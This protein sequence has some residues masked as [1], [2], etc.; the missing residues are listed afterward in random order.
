MDFKD[1]RIQKAFDWLERDAGSD[2]LMPEEYCQTRDVFQARL[3]SMIQVL[4]KEELLKET[5]ALLGAIAGEI[6]NNS[7][8]HNM[9]SWRDVPGV[10]FSYDTKQR[11]IVLADRGQGLLATLKRVAPEL[12][13]ENQAIEMAFTKVI[14]GRAPERRGNG[15]KFVEG[16]VRKYGFKVYFYFNEGMYI[17]NQGLHAGESRDVKGVLAIINF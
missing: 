5:Y 12:E 17:V 11:F 9:G 8:D 7:F 2:F 10:Y 1:I 13:T 4:E 16:W 14:S 6:G 3:G 15:L